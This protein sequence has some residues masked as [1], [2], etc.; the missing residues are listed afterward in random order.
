MRALHDDRFRIGAKNR[1]P[2]K[3]MTRSERLTASYN[4][5]LKA[6]T[7]DTNGDWAAQWLPL[8][9]FCNGVPPLDE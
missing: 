6:A 4:L 7:A 5:R 9:N 3:P 2:I 8:W 1:V